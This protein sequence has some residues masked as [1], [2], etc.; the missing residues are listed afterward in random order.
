M[1]QVR[2]YSFFAVNMQTDLGYFDLFLSDQFLVTCF[3]P[4]SFFIAY[5]YLY[6]NYELKSLRFKILS[7]IC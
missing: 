4:T 6:S 5:D 7:D 3:C 2:V 1:V